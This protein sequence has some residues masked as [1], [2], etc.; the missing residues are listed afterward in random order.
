MPAEPRTRHR[1]FT[2]CG[3]FPSSC[4]SPLSH[5]VSAER[6]GMGQKGKIFGLVFFFFVTWRAVAALPELDLQLVT[7]VVTNPVYITHAG[8]GSG[9]L[10]IVEQNGRIKIFNGTNVLSTPFL[11][12]SSQVL[13]SGE[14]GLLSVAFHPGYA[15]NGQIGRA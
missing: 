9:R 12:I 3:L 10:F 7:S 2:V 6:V 5:V 8:D 15:T 14:E 13:F 1:A 11:D 4:F